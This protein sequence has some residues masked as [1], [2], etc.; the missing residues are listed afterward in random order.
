MFAPITWVL[1]GT[2]TVRYWFTKDSGASTYNSFCDS[3]ASVCSTL[4]KSVTNLS[5][6]RTNANA[7]LQ[8]GFT[9]AAGSLA[10]GAT[11]GELK[12]R[13]QKTDSSNFSETNDYSYRA[14][15]PSYIDWNK[16][17]VYVNGVLAWGTEPS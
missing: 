11:G 10:A 7:Y 14:S 17:T 16:V 2:V 8:V 3:T 15:S 1:A 5:P 4:T 13:V 6:A 9:G 12:L